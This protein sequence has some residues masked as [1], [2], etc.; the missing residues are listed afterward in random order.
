MNVSKS[1]RST[2][3]AINKL[4]FKPQ[5]GVCTPAIALGFVRDSLGFSHLLGTPTAPQGPTAVHRFQCV[6]LPEHISSQCFLFSSALDNKASSCSRCFQKIHTASK[7]VAERVLLPQT[8]QCFLG[9]KSRE[10]CLSD[11][12]FSRYQQ[13]KNRNLGE[14]FRH[15]EINERARG[16][17]RHRE[18]GIE[19]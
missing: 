17:A 10:I 6:L 15:L 14:L 18:D 3:M 12:R 19:R 4:T 16:K 2:Q 7:D 11:V 9:E 8:S 1:Y 13:T 5:L